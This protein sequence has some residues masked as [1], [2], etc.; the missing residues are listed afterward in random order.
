M[1]DVMRVIFYVIVKFSCFI[2]FEFV[3]KMSVPI[4]MKNGEVE[5][6]GDLVRFG[7]FDLDGCHSRIV[8][9]DVDLSFAEH[10]TGEAFSGE[11]ERSYKRG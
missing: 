9:Q 2:C 3:P 7:K 10:I 4:L 6:D 1:S 8:E 5:C 11:D